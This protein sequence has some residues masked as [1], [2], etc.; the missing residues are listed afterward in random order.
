MTPI[1]PQRRTDPEEYVRAIARS[2]LSI[3]DSILIRDP[4]L[5]IPTPQLE[6]LLHSGL[7]GLSLAGLP[8]KT[9]SKV[10]KE[11]VCQILGYPVPNRFRK[12]QPRFPG[13]RFDTYVQKSN[14]LQV[15]NEALSLT[16]RYVVIRISDDDRVLRVRVVTGDFLALLDTTGTLT[17][18]YQARYPIDTPL[19][20][21]LVSP[22]DTTVLGPLVSKTCDLS[23]ASP[24]LP[25]AAGELLD[26]DTV[27]GRLSQVVGTRI[28]DSGID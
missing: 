4:D 9:R 20:T 10:V 13:Q 19:T 5:W 22:A 25:P 21:Q 1:R 2:Q 15:W 14:N 8:L 27:F 7:I 18:K 3:Y 16:R 12:T 6:V 17:Q 24:V 26:I 11:H 28:A 23:R